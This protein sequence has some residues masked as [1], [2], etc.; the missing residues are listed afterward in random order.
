[1]SSYK[2]NINNIAF[3]RFEDCPGPEQ[4][5]LHDNQEVPPQQNQMGSPKL[6]AMLSKPLVSTPPQRQAVSLPATPV[7]AKEIVII[8]IIVFCKIKQLNYFVFSL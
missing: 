5:Q 4:F 7:T 8:T 1:L 3:C 2:F 6:P